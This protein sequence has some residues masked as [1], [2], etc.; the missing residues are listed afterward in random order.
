MKMS[1]WNIGL[2]AKSG[3]RL[4]LIF[5]MVSGD[6][7]VAQELK[8]VETGTKTS[9]RGLSVVSDRIIWASGS[10]GMVALS[11]DGGS[12]FS[13]K[14]VPG[15]ENRDFRDVEGFDGETAVIMAI[16]TP[17]ILLKT[18]DGGKSWKKVFEDRRPGMFLDAMAFRGKWGYVIGD[19]VNGKAFL[20]RTTDGGESWQEM[21]GPEL[22][23]G[24][25]FFASSGSNITVTK[26][27]ALQTGGIEK[28][29]F[30]PLFVSGGMQSRLFGFGIPFELPLRSGKNSS[31]ANGLTLHPEGKSGVIFGG[32]F[33]AMMERDSSMLLFS[34]KEGKVQIKSPEHQPSGYKSHVVYLDDLHLLA[35]GTSGVDVSSDGGNNWRKISDR[36]FHVAGYVSGSDKVVLAGPAG[37]IALF[38]KKDL[39]LK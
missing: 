21:G 35:C 27:D 39:L 37:T 9:L 22:A 32:D 3:F 7:L 5:M 33:A 4:L 19:P 12:H 6:N 23:T 17:A 29:N 15:Y 36:P 31:G 10:R 26:V 11:V 13:W 2:S 16:D 34:F 14:Q 20:A 38:F 18:N 1:I 30:K 8:L 25:A 24:E 28:M